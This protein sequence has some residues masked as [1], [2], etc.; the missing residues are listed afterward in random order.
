M[1]LRWSGCLQPPYRIS[2]PGQAR[3]WGGE[4][5]GHQNSQQPGTVRVPSPALGR[6][7]YELDNE[8]FFSRQRQVQ[9]RSEAP[10]LGRHRGKKTPRQGKE[11]GG[12][13]ASGSG[14]RTNRSRETGDQPAY[15][16]A[17]HRCIFWISA[18]I[19]F[20]FWHRAP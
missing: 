15:S 2:D 9:S 20:P 14:G 3:S 19:Y 16:V 11:V 17:S 13:G 6:P 4:P 8:F 7:A 12:E 18:F 1:Y 10:T 5:E